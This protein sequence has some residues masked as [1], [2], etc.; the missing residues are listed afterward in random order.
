MS[1]SLKRV[2]AALAAAGVEHELRE[3]PDSTRTARQ[4]ADAVGCELEQIAKSIVVEG[5]T[6]GTLTLFITAGGNRVCTARIADL[7]GEPTHPASG[8]RVRE[9]TGFA[10]GG[11]AP[12]G[13]KAPI[14]SYFDPRL[15]TF[16]QIWAAAGTPRHVFRIS[17]DRL[18]EISGAIEAD[19]IET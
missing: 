14:R 1:K 3:M 15:G 6:S 4:A 5:E 16:D 9:I 2:K 8:T 11:V 19:F 17:P 7:L 13:H 10:I 12:V 18:R